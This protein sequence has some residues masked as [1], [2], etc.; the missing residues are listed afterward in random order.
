MIVSKGQVS[1][2]C[3]H[4]WVPLL[5]LLLLCVLVSA[6]TLQGHKAC[7]SALKHLTSSCGF[8]SSSLGGAVTWVDRW[9][10]SAGVYGCVCGPEARQRATKYTTVRSIGQSRPWQQHMSLTTGTASL[11]RRRLLLWASVLHQWVMSQLQLNI[12]I[13]KPTQ[14]RHTGTHTAAATNPVP[15]SSVL[16]PLVLPCQQH[17][18]AVLMP[19]H[20]RSDAA[21]ACSSCLLCLLQ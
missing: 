20:G 3:K 21:A 9:L 19:Q 2:L 10:T 13:Q 12:C 11:A 1:W 5:L 18:M 7:N 16:L 8:S 15:F 4:C 17:S 14:H 6:E